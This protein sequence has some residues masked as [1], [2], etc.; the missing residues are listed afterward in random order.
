VAMSKNPKFLRTVSTIN[1][2]LL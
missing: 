1:T 2:L